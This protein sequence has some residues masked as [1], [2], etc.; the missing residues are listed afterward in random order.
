[1]DRDEAVK[2]WFSP[3]RSLCALCEKVKSNYDFHLSNGKVEVISKYC[4]DCRD[5]DYEL[6][7]K[8]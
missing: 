6:R 7:H 5:L 4:K 3:G 1:M 2:Q 8:G